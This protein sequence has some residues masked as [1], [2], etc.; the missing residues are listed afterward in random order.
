MK[1]IH[2]INRCSIANGAAKLL[3]DIVP[4]QI[5]LGHQVDILALASVNPSNKDQFEQIGCKYITILEEG[6]SIKSISMSL[7]C[8]IK[9]I[10]Q[11]YDIVHAHLFPSFY[12]VALVKFIFKINAKIVFTEHA[13]ENNRRK[14]LLIPIERFIYRQYDAIIAISGAVQD[15]LLSFL[16]IKLPIHTVFN[17]IN[18]EKFKNASPLNRLQVRIPQDCFV[19]TQVSRFGPE[20]DQMTLIKAL[21]LLPSEIHLVLVGN[22]PLLGKHISEVKNLQLGNRVHFLGIRNDIPQI[23]QMSDVVILSSHF[24]GFGLAAVEGMAANKPLIASNV[25]GL[26]QVVQGAGLLFEE[27]NVQELNEHIL[28]LYNNREYYT[29]IAEQCYVRSLI[30]DIVNVANQYDDIYK[31]IL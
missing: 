28:N 23:M 29:K 24:E 2:V 22:G 14:K 31:T 30:Y 7:F 15:N 1:I 8:R 25:P 17:G 10:I 11:Q 26:N 16:K 13:S 19:L 3:L 5:S 12:W 4:H 27:G 18:I 20:K 6:K 9:E 21:K